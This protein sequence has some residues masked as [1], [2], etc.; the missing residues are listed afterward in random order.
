[1]NPIESGPARFGEVGHPL[2]HHAKRRRHRDAG[3]GQD[4]LALCHGLRA[5]RA[6]QLVGVHGGLP[7]VHGQGGR[8][9]KSWWLQGDERESILTNSGLIDLEHVGNCSN[10]FGVIIILLWVCADKRAIDPEVMVTLWFLWGK[11]GFKPLE[12]VR[13]PYKQPLPF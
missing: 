13:V 7:G 12:D 10:L 11:Q 1:M 5:G 2:R 9:S 6:L 8:R 4:V 3:G